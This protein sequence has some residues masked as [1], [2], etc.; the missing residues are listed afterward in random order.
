[1]QYRIEKIGIHILAFMVAG[2]EL[3]GMYPFVVPFFMASYLQ[4]R[5]SISVF[6]VLLLGILSRLAW[7]EALRYGIILIF[8]MVLLNRTKREVIFSGT[9]QIAM[10]S[11]MILW[12]V[13][14]PFEYLVTGREISVVYTFFE[15]VIVCCA[16]C[17]FEQGFAA[18]KSGTSRIFADNKRF[19]GVF[20][21]MAAALF[22]CPDI[23]KPV[24]LMFVIVSYLIMYCSYRFDGS[25]GITVGS[26]GGLVL[27][28]KQGNISYLAIMIVIASLIA[29]LR[30][31][32]KA[33]VLLAYVAG[34]ILLGVLY[35]NDLLTVS[36][37]TGSVVAA[38]LF[39]VTPRKALKRIVV[40]REE[41]TRTSQDILVQEATKRQIE[42]FGQAFLAMEQMLSLHERQWEDEIPTGL[43]NMYLSGD[44]ISL[45]NAVE[46]E[47]SRLA[48]LRRNFIRQ[49]K[50]VGEIITGFQGEILEES[51]SLENFEA[52]VMERCGRRGVEVTKAVCLKDRDGRLSV[53]IRCRTRESRIVS[54]KMLAKSIG[55]IVGK[56]L[57]CMDRAGDLVGKEESIFSFIEEG[58]YTLTTGLVRK[59]RTGES[60]CGDNFSIIK[61]DNG[62]AVCMISDGMG[63]GENA[64]VK[65][66]Q[67]MDLLE[68]LLSAGFGRELAVE[69]LNSFISFITDGS[70][71]STLDL[72]MFDLYTG[73]ADFIKLGASTTFIRHG[74]KVELIRSTTLPVGVLED[75]EFDTCARK[76]Y[77]GD[78]V[79]MVSDGVL[80]G[81]NDEDKDEYLA[82]LVASVDTENMQVLAQTIMDDICDMQQ[83]MLRDDSTVLAIGIWEHR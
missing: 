13:S 29:L 2:C 79:V 60:L 55:Y 8:L 26:I 54:G 37:L 10:A 42:N 48:D 76:L 12:G 30:E 78:V 61:L 67:V 69:L 34:I 71:S 41:V 63:S 14:M 6:A 53:L 56:R 73:M 15:G 18:V 65:S 52:R 16:T 39:M 5:S 83:G 3:M 44:G 38:G 77:H 40:R 23:E 19:I 46:S 59:K 1:M 25:I 27:A 17:V 57:V 36:L 49:L 82:G 21:I 7:Q 43:S 51:L 58:N 70:G 28:F 33:G 32:G 31:I 72:S 35:E 50:Q 45:L 11:G 9:F 66:K 24:P 47:R 64:Y 68:Q 20:S 74:K 62:K 4:D 75:I 81:I 80:D 22:G